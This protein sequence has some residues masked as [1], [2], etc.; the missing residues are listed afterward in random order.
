MIVFVLPGVNDLVAKSV[1]ENQGEEAGNREKKRDIHDSRIF[2]RSESD[3]SYRQD[4]ALTP[5]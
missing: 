2:L 5:R 3:I 1:R 4:A